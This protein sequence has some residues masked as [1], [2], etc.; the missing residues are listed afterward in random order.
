MVFDYLEQIWSISGKFREKTENFLSINDKSTPRIQFFRQKPP[1]TI[2]DS[3]RIGQ[4]Q[5][6]LGSFYTRLW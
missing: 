5:E 6:K 1:K 2:P 3:P 4:N